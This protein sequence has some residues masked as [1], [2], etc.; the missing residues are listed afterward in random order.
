[1]FFFLYFQFYVATY[2]LC[3]AASYVGGFWGATACNVATVPRTV[4]CI[5]N[6]LNNCYY[7]RC[8]LVNFEL[9]F[10]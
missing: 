7:K 3:G 5:N 6:A 4:D 10:Q 9:P 8:G 1:M 2:G